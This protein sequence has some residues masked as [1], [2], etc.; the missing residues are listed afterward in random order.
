MLCE[1]NGI[2]CAVL[3]RIEAIGGGAI[4]SGGWPNRQYT[5]VKEQ[6]NDKPKNDK[7][8]YSTMLLIWLS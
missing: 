2:S 1:S 7:Y 8:L 6:Q 4:G 5:L 3:N